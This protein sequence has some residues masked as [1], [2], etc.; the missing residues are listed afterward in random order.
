MCVMNIAEVAYVVGATHAAGPDYNFRE[1]LK[2]YHVAIDMVLAGY[3]SKKL[4][5]SSNSN[6]PTFELY[7]ILTTAF[8]N[9]DVDLVEKLFDHYDLPLMTPCKR[10][11]SLLDQG[12]RCSHHSILQ[13]TLTKLGVGIREHKYPVDTLYHP[14]KSYLAHILNHEF[15]L[16]RAAII[17]ECHERTPLLP[18]NDA[19]YRQVILQFSQP[20]IQEDYQD[21]M[22]R[23]TFVKALTMWNFPFPIIQTLEHLIYGSTISMA[24]SSK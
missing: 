6:A 12:L 20:N 24:C 14:E 7:S 2:H 17:Q 10:I 15:P 13:M 16:R 11:S 19:G 5:V 23:K 8:T 9:E 1:C 22:R 18:T 21:C 3:P 4:S